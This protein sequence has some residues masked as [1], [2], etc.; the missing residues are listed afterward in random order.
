MHNRFVYCHCNHRNDVLNNIDSLADQ[1]KGIFPRAKAILM[2]Q[3][4]WHENPYK[5]NVE[6]WSDAC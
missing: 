6:A 2:P 3:P 4:V 5:I 1:V